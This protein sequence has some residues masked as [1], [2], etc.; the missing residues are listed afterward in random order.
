MKTP[1]LTLIATFALSAVSAELTPDQI[2]KAQ[3]LY[4]SGCLPCH[5]KPGAL[6]PKQYSDAQWNR[7]M[8]RMLPK[9]E[10]SADDKK[11]L[12]DYLA[13]V[14]AGKTELPKPTPPAKTGKKT[15]KTNPTQ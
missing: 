6:D 7:C 13:A 12:T 4:Q 10:L 3:Q 9:S 1:V 2:K 14:R 11:L 15:K 5:K 8:E